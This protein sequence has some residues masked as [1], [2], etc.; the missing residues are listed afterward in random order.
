[1]DGTGSLDWY[2]EFGD[3][4][5]KKEVPAVTQR[6]HMRR[7]LECIREDFAA[8][9]QVIRP[10]GGL[11]S[12]SMANNTS[13]NAARMGFGIA[14]WNWAVYLDTQLALSLESVS[15][16]GAWEYDRRI[17]ASDI[18]WTV[19]AP[20][21]LGFHDRDLALDGQAFSRLLS[22]LGD[23]IRY[24]NG[25][26]YSA[27]LHAN[28]R[29]TPVESLQLTVEYDTHYSGYFASHPSRWTVHLS[30]QTRSALK[31]AAAEKQTVELP[32]GLGKRILW[33]IKS[34]GTQPSG[35]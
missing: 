10:G 16:R 8:T 18:P 34:Q 26:E 20:Y 22:G 14:T 19:D 23:G 7:A 2:N 1:M 28:V 15:R 3:G 35:R 33:D 32:P 5:R 30:D 21:W 9:P 4:L 29:G 17:T 6:L 25:S 24:M 27:Y 13:V 31:V 11:Y 12:K